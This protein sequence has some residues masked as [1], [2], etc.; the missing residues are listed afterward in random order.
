MKA[1]RHFEEFLREN[2]VKKQKPDISRAEFLIQES[3]RS[4][5]LLIKKIRLL[6]ISKETANDLVKSCY[7]IIMESLRAE[8]L[9]KGYNASG[10]GAHEAEVAYLRLLKFAEA[11]VRFMD[12]LRYLRNGILYYGKQVDREYAEKVIAFT[13]RLQPGLR[14]LAEKE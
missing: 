12:Q 2:T 14:R 3:G 1:I 9:L 4:Y 8:M 5:S 6:G 7:D 13:K 10:H 11:D